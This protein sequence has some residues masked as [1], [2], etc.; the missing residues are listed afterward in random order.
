MGKEISPSRLNILVMDLASL[1]PEQ[2]IQALGE[3][4]LSHMDTSTYDGDC[5]N[6]W[7]HERS[8]VYG[9]V[10]FTMCKSYDMAVTT[11]NVHHPFGL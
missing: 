6:F 4:S 8:A 1:F 10:Y 11:S 5:I 2:N 3:I 7:S 9:V